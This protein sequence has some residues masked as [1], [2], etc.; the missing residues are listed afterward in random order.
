[1]LVLDGHESAVY[2]LA[3]DPA[4]GRL[5]TGDAAG[6]VLLW[7]G[8]GPRRLSA[9]DPPGGATVNGLAFAPDAATLVEATSVGLVTV[10]LHPEAVG[11][12][13][14]PRAAPYGTTGVAFAGPKLLALGYGH[15]GKPEGG[16]FKLHHAG[17]GRSPEFPAP[18]GVRS[19]SAAGQVVAWA[20]WGR[21]LYAW[22]VRKPDRVKL[23]LTA[24]SMCVALS[25]DGLQLAAG[26]DDYKVRL[27]D[28]AGKRERLVLGGHS[29]RVT[30]VAFTPDG[31]T[32][33]SGGWD[34]TVRLWDAASGAERAVFRWPV[35]G[36]VTALAVSPDG[37]RLA[38][39]GIAGA[40]VLADLD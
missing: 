26:L 31:G 35:G 27:F 40:V 24:E 23:P 39:G 8:G 1:M 38:V 10:P 3:F 32:V 11:F 25:P 21:L 17:G 34:G 6:N 33:V 12:T 9:A 36:K 16:A 28:L 30:G 22:D 19:V 5:A 15:R 13:V 4:G 2:A 29:G 20:E 37:L 7:A 14:G 18:K